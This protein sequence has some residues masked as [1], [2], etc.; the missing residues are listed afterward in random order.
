[1][2][3][4]E[5][6]LRNKRI[7]KYLAISIISISMIFIVYI[8]PNY[9]TLVL[10]ILLL[11]LLNILM[12]IKLICNN[13]RIVMIWRRI[14]DWLNEFDKENKSN[15]INNKE[16]FDTKSLGMVFSNRY[17]D[18]IIKINKIARGLKKSVNNIKKNERVNIELINN[19]TNKLN[20]P[21][22]DILD[23]IN[24][25]KID[26]DNKEIVDL[27]KN[28]SNN[29]NKLIEELFEASKTATGDMILEINE[30]EIIEFLRQ[31]TIEYEDKIFNSKLTFRKNFPR[32]NIY[33]CC[34]GEK[35]WRVFD[36]L[37][38]NAIKHS[39][40][41]SRVYID[42]NCNNNKVYIC[43][44]NTSKKELNIMPKDLIYIINN[45]DEEDVSGLGLEIAKNLILLQKG[46]F[47][48]SIDGDLFK[49]EIVFD[50]NSIQEA[51]LE[52]GVN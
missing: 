11:I 41:N 8:V 44:K 35:L 32:K 43:I 15:A 30:I 48:I 25:L 46:D 47:N 19:L 10:I 13:L 12:I 1:M 21:L 5:F 37:F 24:K 23:N 50:I 52:K 51:P 4:R 39:L 6:I 18:L 16:V 40:E 28:K 33:I 26:V 49:V 9:K 3:S 29:L 45:N 2:K 20:N 14:E 42:V 38:E 7:L 27:L 31:A 34:S 22:E 36:I 17:F